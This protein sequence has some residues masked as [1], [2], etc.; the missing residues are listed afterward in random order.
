MN[1]YW[2]PGDRYRCRCDVKN[3]DRWRRLNAAERQGAI[4]LYCLDCRGEWVSDTRYAVGLPL[5]KKESRSGMTVDEVFDLITNGTYHVCP[6]TATVTRNGRPL[7]PVIRS[8]GDDPSRG[9]Y[10]FINICSRGRKR[11]IALHRAVWM[12]FNEDTVPEGYDI[13]HVFGSDRGDEIWNLRLQE[14]GEN[15]AAGARKANSG[16]CDGQEEFPW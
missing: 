11:K 5:H 7:K 10:R 1:Q 12:A 14:S 15:R 13:D 9:T 2:K 6:M 8:R 3:R 4:T 16:R